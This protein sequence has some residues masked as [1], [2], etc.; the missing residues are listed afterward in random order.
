MLALTLG[1]CSSDT[2][3]KHEILKRGSSKVKVQE[4]QLVAGKMEVYAEDVLLHSTGDY[5]DIFMQYSASGKSF[6]GDLLDG[7]ELLNEGDSAK[8]Y[9]NADSLRKIGNLP[10]IIKDEVIYVVKVDRFL[11]MEDVEEYQG[12]IRAQAEEDE[13]AKIASF[14]KENA[15]DVEPQ[16][17]GIYFI[18]TKE[19]N[20]KKVEKDK[21]V[22]FHYTGSLLNGKVFDSSVEEI[23]KAAGLDR[24][25]FEPLESLAGASQLIPGMDEALLMMRVG[26]CAKVVIPFALAYGDRNMG[27]SIPR[28]STLVFDLEILEVE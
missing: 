25:N 12:A 21:K 8:F 5:Y 6:E 19:G 15:I 22:K 17:S 18:K 7:I 24:P 2:K 23:A 4:N 3:I 27:T 11:N 20:G 1:A 13:K 16:A 26:D 14:V 28:F 10:E 9:I